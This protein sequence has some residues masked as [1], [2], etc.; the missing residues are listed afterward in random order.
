MDWLS[1]SSVVSRYVHS[2]SDSLPALDSV[3]S[4]SGADDDG[5]VRDRSLATLSLCR[6]RRRVNIFFASSPSLTNVDVNVNREF[7]TWLKQ[8]KLLQSAKERKVTS[9]SQWTTHCWN[10]VRVT[11]AIV[12]SKAMNITARAL[13]K[14]RGGIQDREQM[15][16]KMGLEGKTATDGEEVMCW[17]RLFQTRAAATGKARS[18]TVD[19]R[20]RL[21][22]SDE[23]EAERS[24]WWVLTSA[25]WQSSLTRN[26]GAEPWRYLYTRTAHLKATHC[27]AFT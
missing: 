4:S 25:T 6:R 11:R 13:Y 22:I 5:D 16:L 12:V 10:T 14:L 8:P 21:T 15:S 17:E 23:D 9:V 18:T 26:D 2:D 24:R 3:S 1:W 7:L 20:V 27:G 19:S